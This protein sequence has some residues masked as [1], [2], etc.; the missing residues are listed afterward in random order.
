MS[1][2]KHL[3]CKCQ[4]TCYCRNSRSGSSPARCPHAHLVFLEK[5]FLEGGIPIAPWMRPDYMYSE[6]VYK[7]RGK[8]F[9]VKSDKIWI[10]LEEAVDQ[11]LLTHD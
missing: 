8:W 3:E 10:T 2:C 4:S 11:G 5:K 6:T 9:Y 7:S 1:V